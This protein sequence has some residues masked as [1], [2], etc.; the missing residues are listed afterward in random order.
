MRRE[1]LSSLGQHR[2]APAA[3]CKSSGLLAQAECKVFQEAAW[4]PNER[5]EGPWLA[6]SR[7]FRRV[8]TGKPIGVYRVRAERAID[9]AGGLGYVNGHKSK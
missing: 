7:P 5:W 2:N 6:A 8:V 9:A 3:L 4:T 1:Q